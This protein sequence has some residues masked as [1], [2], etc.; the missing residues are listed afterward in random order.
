M[1]GTVLERTQEPAPSAPE[2]TRLDAESTAR[3]RVVETAKSM[4][5]VRYRYGGSTPDGFDCSGLVRFSYERGGFPELPRSSR[6]QFAGTQRIGL[7]ELVPGDL[8]FFRFRGRDVSHVGIYVGGGEFVHAAKTT[9]RVERVRF[10]HPYWRRQ[11]QIA[12]RVRWKT[13]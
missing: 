3:A 5:G 4:I 9:R 2:R 8:L 11:I 10:D 12:G 1:R 7:D 13:R 6:A